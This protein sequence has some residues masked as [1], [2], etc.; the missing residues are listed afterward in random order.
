MAVEVSRLKKADISGGS[1]PSESGR[2]SLESAR[3]GESNDIGLAAS[4]WLERA[5]GRK[6]QIP[7]WALADV[8]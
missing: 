4:A 5:G 7:H 3:T 8:C 1:C 2:V 6:R